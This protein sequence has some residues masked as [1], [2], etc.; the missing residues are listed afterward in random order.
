MDVFFFLYPAKN[1]KCM[2]FLAS[3]AQSVYPVR[4]S[5]AASLSTVA[6]TLMQIYEILSEDYEQFV[7][8]IFLSQINIVCQGAQWFS[9]RV[10]DS[11]QRGRGF[12]THRRHCVVVLEQDT[13][14]LA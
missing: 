13:F 3:C 7:V 1:K 12:E 4:P 8:Q 6:Q 2:I 10:L 14:I 5:T 11:R 9:G